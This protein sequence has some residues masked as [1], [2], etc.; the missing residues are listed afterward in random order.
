LSF[1]VLCI[2]HN[3]KFF[4]MA[5]DEE[6]IKEQGVQPVPPPA[7]AVPAE[8]VP[9]E[10]TPAEDNTPGWKKRVKEY[11]KDR[12]FQDD[13]EMSV[14]AEEMIDDLMD[15]KNKGQ[16]ASERLVA[17]MESEPSV[18]DLIADLMD[19]ASLPEALAKNIDLDGITP[20]EDDPDYG[21]W[22]EAK[23]NR[24]EQVQAQ[25]QF[26]ED[27]N[28]NKV[29]SSK[30]FQAFAEEKDLGEE[31]T[32]AFLDKVDQYLDDIYRGKVSKEFLDAMFKATGYDE[33]LVQARQEASTQAKNEKV[34]AKKKE[35]K[36][37]KG[38]GL[39][40][41]SGTGTPIEKPRREKPAFLSRLEKIEEKHK[42][43][44]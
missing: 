20:M 24:M 11:F 13:D 38:D 2:V 31:E 15:Y 33:A 34:E 39:P 18:A 22:E 3:Y 9:V 44:I 8:K 23:N 5:E 1:K 35:Y 43:R 26:D 17:L 32:T 7:E 4:N 14:A 27:L 30:N 19:G 12:E 36:K 6:V 10:E 29:E 28:G 21:K 37:P 16:E 42:R 25:K 40:E 41:V